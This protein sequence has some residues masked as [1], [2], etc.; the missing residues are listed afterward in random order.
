MFAIAV[1]GTATQIVNFYTG[2]SPA[3]FMCKGH[4]QRVRSINWFDS[5]M[6]FVSAGQ[7]G[8]V[9]FWDLINAKENAKISDKDFT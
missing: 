4:Q 9:Y 8:D 7:A 5:D 6:G 1:G 2:E 3:Y